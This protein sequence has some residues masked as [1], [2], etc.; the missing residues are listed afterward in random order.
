MLS[1][2]NALKQALAGFQRV[3]ANL[4]ADPE[5]RAGADRAGRPILYNPNPRAAN[6]TMSHWDPIASPNQLMEP[7]VA[8]DLSHSV[9]PPNDLTLSVLKDLGWF[10][11]FDGVPDGADQCPGSDRS[12]TVVIQGCDT[13]VPNST[14]RTGCRISD[15]FKPCDGLAG[16]SR[17]FN[18]CVASA[19]RQLVHSGMVP[20]R[21]LSGIHACITQSSRP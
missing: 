12:A 5:V 19:S 4:L 20:P 2:G 18:S 1:D 17:A 14:F 11:D 9:E 6:S 13:R 10:S 3:T 16:D 21:Q 8:T 15:Y 7:D